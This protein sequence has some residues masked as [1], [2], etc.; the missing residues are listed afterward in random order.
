MTQVRVKGYVVGFDVIGG[1]IRWRVKVKDSRSEY[2]GCNFPVASCYPGTMLTRPAVD[3]SFVLAPVPSSG[4]D[5]ECFEGRLRAFEVSFK[6]VVVPV[7]DVCG[8]DAEVL[9]EMSNSKD[10]SAHCAR[11]CL[12]HLFQTIKGLES[13]ESDSANRHLRFMNV[14]NG[15]QQWRSGL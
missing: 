15:D 1:A 9:L 5:V 2:N 10:N 7:C 6:D 11:C 12:P 4:T 14:F 3:V 13:A 8:G